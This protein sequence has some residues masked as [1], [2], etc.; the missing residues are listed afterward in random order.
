MY[1]P[2]HWKEAINKSITIY[3]YPNPPNVLYQADNNVATSQLFPIMKSKPEIFFSYAWD[4]DYREKLVNQL[5]E[6]LLKDNY[7][8]IRDKY[9][10]EY[11]GLI[12]AF[13]DRLGKGKCIVVVISKKYLE[14]EYCMFELYEIARQSNFDKIQ[15]REKVILIMVEYVDF[16]NPAIIRHYISFG[17][18]NIKN[19]MT[20]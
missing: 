9:D 12:S 13:I 8:V 1:L 20:W 11:N 3:D 5:Y 14:S 17:K 6:S 10:L 4:D 19:G 7:N 16:N 15:F 18:E 2:A